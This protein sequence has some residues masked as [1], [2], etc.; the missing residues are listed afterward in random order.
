MKTRIND[1]INNDAFK[2]YYNFLIEE[3]KKLRSS[4]LTLSKVVYDTNMML[5]SVMGIDVPEKM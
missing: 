1:I 2:K 5:L 4:W 3:N